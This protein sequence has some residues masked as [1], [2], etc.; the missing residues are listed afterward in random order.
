MLKLAYYTLYFLAFNPTRVCD[1][2]E[3]W[4]EKIKLLSIALLC[5]ATTALQQ[6]KI[7]WNDSEGNNITWEPWKQDIQ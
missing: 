7:K 6:W 1:V 3:S 5:C 2:V 4:W